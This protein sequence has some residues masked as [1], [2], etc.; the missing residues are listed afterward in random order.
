V[1]KYCRAG[2]ATDGSTTLV[3]CV[4]DTSGYKHTLRVCNAFLKLIHESRNDKHKIYVILIAF[5]RQ[6]WLSERTSMLRCTYIASLA[7]LSFLFLLFFF[8]ICNSLNYAVTIFCRI[9]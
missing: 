8:F 9:Q 1:E 2:Q 3:Y 5:S 6:Q 7:F 4:P